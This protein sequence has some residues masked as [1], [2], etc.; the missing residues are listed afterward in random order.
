MPLGPGLPGLK[1]GYSKPKGLLYLQDSLL[2]LVG[3]PWP[4]ETPQ[5]V[6]LPAGYNMNVYMK[7]ALTDTVI[8]GDQGPVGL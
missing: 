8:D 3:L 6:L 7:H 4:E 2:I 1:L 5:A